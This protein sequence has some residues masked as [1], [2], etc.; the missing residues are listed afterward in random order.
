M[1]GPGSVVA[2]LTVFGQNHPTITLPI[3]SLILKHREKKKVL[4]EEQIL[5][6]FASCNSQ[7]QSVYD[8]RH[9]LTVQVGYFLW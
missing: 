2:I 4:K 6:V 1:I 5:F 3:Y 9:L 7:I 8:Q